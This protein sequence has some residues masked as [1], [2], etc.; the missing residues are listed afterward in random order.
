[1]EDS[2]KK[3]DEEVYHEFSEMSLFTQTIYKLENKFLYRILILKRE[4][5]IGMLILFLK[6]LRDLS[7]FNLCDIDYI[8]I[9]I[10]II[11]TKFGMRKKE[12]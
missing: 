1:L 3:N 8:S 10:F 11:Y 9:I 6:I 5:H 4:R 7:I 12:T 2:N